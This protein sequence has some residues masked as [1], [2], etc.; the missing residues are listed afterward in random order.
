MLRLDDIAGYVSERNVW[1]LLLTLSD[2]SKEYDLAQLTAKDI[3]VE[4]NEFHIKKSGDGQI[5]ENAVWNIGALAFYALMGV[6]VFGGRAAGELADADVPRISSSHAGDELSSLLASCLS[7]DSSDRPDLA[8]INAKAKSVLEHKPHRSKSI[9]T[10]SGRRYSESLVKFWP[11]EM[12]GIFIFVITLFCSLPTSAQ[13]QS[14]N[15]TEK[16]N[17]IVQRCIALRLPDSSEKVSNE[18]SYDV[19]WTLLDEIAIDKEG[20]CTIN[21]PV[22]ILGVNDLCSRIL[23]YR[24]G[25]VNTRGQFV[26]GQDPRYKYSL[27]EI[28]VK[29]GASVC[30][31]IERR[32]GTQTF[33]VIP[34]DGNN[35]FRV[36][37][38]QDGH[39]IGSAVFIDGVCYFSVAKKMTPE[40]KFQLNIKNESGKNMSYV[41][42]NH[43]ARE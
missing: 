42:I 12:M 4:D 25:V 26:N 34:Y 6:E 27:I 28:T 8:S 36:W 19:E 39:N 2:V 24:S 38:E 40:D 32:Q 31:E 15:I 22:N 30:Y 10:D 9:V 23:K 35:S 20:E 21:D 1:K 14:V 33:A 29:Q 16:M 37:V 11:E 13:E 7:S 18:F 41:I 5:S 3:Y 43:N 17:I